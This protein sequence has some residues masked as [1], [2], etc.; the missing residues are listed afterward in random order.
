MVTKGSA[1][2]KPVGGSIAGKQAGLSNTDT[3]HSTDIGKDP[4]KSKKGEGVP[5]TAKVQGTVNPS[6]KQV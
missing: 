2:K 4:D 3:K 1:G 6:R 5:E